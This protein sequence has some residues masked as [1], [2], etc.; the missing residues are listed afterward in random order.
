MNQKLS[1]ATHDAVSKKITVGCIPTTE[2]R[3]RRFEASSE[4]VVEHKPRENHYVVEEWSCN[5]VRG[6]DASDH[7]EDGVRQCSDGT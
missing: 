7:F 1:A 2:E 6:A 3:V 5:C 4:C